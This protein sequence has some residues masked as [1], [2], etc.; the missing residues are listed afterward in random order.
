MDQEQFDNI[1]KVLGYPENPVLVHFTDI[2]TLS[3]TMSQKDVID[4]VSKSGKVLPKQKDFTV[5][6]IAV[7][8]GKGE[9]LKIFGKEL[10][11]EEQQTKIKEWHEKSKIKL[12]ELR[13][14]YNTPS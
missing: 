8:D 7:S 11:S 12:E 3:K 14:K 10:L 1:L 13:G 5:I 9:R 2:E 4:Y 6:S